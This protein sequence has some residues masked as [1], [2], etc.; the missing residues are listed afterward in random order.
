M[1]LISIFLHDEFVF[2]RKIAMSKMG[3]MGHFWAQNQHFLTSLK[4][5][6]LAFSE[7]KSDNRH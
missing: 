6:S 2:L 5:C 4:I 3:K 7:I 1:N